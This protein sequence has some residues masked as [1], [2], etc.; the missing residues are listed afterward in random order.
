MDFRALNYG[1]PELL[2]L[3]ERSPSLCSG[4]ITLGE[5][6][7]PAFFLSTHD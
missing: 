6:A 4:S 3:I 2:S 7:E 5:G 1:H